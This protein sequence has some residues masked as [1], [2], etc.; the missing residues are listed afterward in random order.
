MARTNP[1]PMESCLEY[2][3]PVSSPSLIPIGTHYKYVRLAPIFLTPWPIPLF[4]LLGELQRLRRRVAEQ[5]PGRSPRPGPAGGYSTGGKEEAALRLL[6]RLWVCC[7]E[8]DRGPVER[9]VTREGRWFRLDLSRRDADSLRSR[10]SRYS[11]C[12][13]KCSRSNRYNTL[14]FMLGTSSFRLADWSWPPPSTSSTLIS[15]AAPPRPPSPP[16]PSHS[17]TIDRRHRPLSRTSSPVRVVPP[18]AARS[19]TGS[20]FRTGRRTP[21]H[22]RLQRQ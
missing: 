2:D 17:R 4:G 6:A 20:P 12:F 13:E 5:P 11:A 18:S 15:K 16:L 19:P 3:S 10:C 1:P 14:D 21:R 9:A 7:A 22:R 8:L